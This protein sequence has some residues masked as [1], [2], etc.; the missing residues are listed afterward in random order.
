[1][2]VVLSCKN[3]IGGGSGK[4]HRDMVPLECDILTLILLP[5]MKIMRPKVGGAPPPPG[6]GTFPPIVN[7]YQ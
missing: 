2:L 5:C 4:G 3:Y 7:D 6:R 1:M